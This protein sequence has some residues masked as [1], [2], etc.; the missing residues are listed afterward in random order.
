MRRL[1]GKL[2]A[3]VKDP[4]KRLMRLPSVVNWARHNSQRLDETKSRLKLF[5]LKPPRHSLGQVHKLCAKIAY[6][7]HDFAS[8]MSEIDKFADPMVRQAAREIIPAFCQYASEFALDGIEELDG[9]AI[10]FP[11]G[12]GPDG[13]TLFVPIK[14]TFTV[15]RKDQLT[16]YF[17]IGWATLYLNDFQKKLIS[18]IIMQSYLSQQDYLL[19]D[20][21][22]IGLPRIKYTKTR[23]HR[24]WE[25][26]SYATLSNEQLADQFIRYGRA[27]REVIKELSVP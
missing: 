27:L 21:V 8:A 25:V 13:K 14:P 26:K 6:R 9:I 2:M 10:P 4:I 3:D 22:V 18:T 20:A 23:Y 16:P 17:V 19:S 12:Q 5:A 1:T 11:V 7:K 24:T 15:A